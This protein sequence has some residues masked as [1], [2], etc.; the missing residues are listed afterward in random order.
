MTKTE[1]KLD[2]YGEMATR[3][4]GSIYVGVVGP[5]RTGKST[6]IAR[7]MEKVILPS[8]G[9]DAARERA[10]DELP[11]SAAGKT[12][13]TAEPKFIPDE[14]VRC[15]TGD[16][17][18]IAVRLID[19]V[20]YP[21]PEA[22][23]QTED[24]SPRMVRTPW[25]DQPI[26]FAEAAETGTRKVI[27]DH[28]TIA[29][30]VTTDG[31]VCE[32]PREAYEEAEERVVE[33]LRR[34]RR[35]FAILLNSA[36]PANAETVKLAYTLEEKYGAPVALINCREIEE[37]D[38]RSILGLILREFPLRELR[39]KMPAW[40]MALDAGHPLRETLR[41]AVDAAAASL[42]RMGDAPGF[43][44]CFD[45]NGT[46]E[47]AAVLSQDF[48]TGVTEA[49]LRLP[50]KLYYEVISE[51][52]G[53]QIG[54]DHALVDTLRTLSA[55]AKK[56]DKVAEALDKVER[57]GYGIVMPEGAELRLEEPEIVKIAG[58]YGVKL[59]AAAP[60]IHMVRADIET[61][62]RPIVGTEQQS[63]ELV[64][65]L[66]DGYRDDPAALWQTNLFGRTLF[67]LVEEGLAAK[68]TNMPE[69]ARKK[70][71]DTLSR[72]VNEG[73]AGLLCILL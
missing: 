27:T 40:V 56:Y 73:T 6:L 54:D 65:Y 32:I 50:T 4:G 64:K 71:G 49:E 57:D 18:E 47:E 15:R 62:L 41:T 5:V 25:N 33:E 17:A 36:D 55:K 42:L 3:T 48:A 60:S 28:C 7:M 44:A 13:M 52:T 72:I 34:S 10:R 29:L 37:D 59:R 67:E 61:E 43:A 23:G 22:L 1:E 2:I 20:G 51:L 66:L 39:V 21:I 45:G 38:I 35:P 46:V 9:E 30:L 11:Q 69:D 14:P 19:C 26:A 16:G 63:E 31:S 70:L 24:G 53:L 68:L 8:I 58:G 12:V